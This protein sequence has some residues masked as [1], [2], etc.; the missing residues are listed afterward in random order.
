MPQTAAQQALTVQRRAKAAEMAAAGASFTEIGR[1][2]GVT[3]QRAHSI[4]RAACAAILAP[5]VEA[6]RAEQLAEL[7]EARERVMRVM[8]ADHPFVQQGHVVSEI[9]D[10]DAEGKPVYGDPLVDDGPI[11]DAARTLA[12]LH[13]REAKLLGADAPT[14]VEASV[15]EHIDPASIELRQLI[16]AQRARNAADL[17]ALGGRPDVEDTVD[18]GEPA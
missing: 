11:L 3:K 10:H 7:A 17:A 9:V 1:E 13:A 15:T 8:R 6:A 12:T 14:K 4:F 16:E 2:L 18:G 5:A